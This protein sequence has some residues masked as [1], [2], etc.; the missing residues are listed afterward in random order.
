M[1]NNN[2]I[3]ISAGV[4]SSEQDFTF[5]SNQIIGL[6][7]LGI[8]GEMKKGQAF[9]PTLVQSYGEYLECFGNCDPCV[10]K[11]T[12]QPIYEASFIAKQFLR[13]SNS[14]YVTRVLGL[15][16]YNAGTGWAITLGG[17]IDLSTATPIE[18]VDFTMTKVYND[19]SCV[20]VIFDD[21]T[22]QTLYDCGQI[23]CDDLGSV[24]MTSGD[25]I[26][27][28]TRWYGDCEKFFGADLTAELLLEEEK[29][30]C[31]TGSTLTGT[32]AD[33]VSTSV[34]GCTIF[35][36]GSVTYGAT[37]TFDLGNGGCQVSLIDTSSST[38]RIIESGVIQ[39]NG[40]TI[41]HNIDGTI[42]IEDGT[43]IL[44]SGE[45]IHDGLY[46]ICKFECAELKYLGCVDGINIT[47]QTGETTATTQVYVT[48]TT[49]IVAKVPSG[50]VTQ[51]WSGS[52]NHYEALPKAEYDNRVVA[53]LRS[54]AYYDS[55][56][57]LTFEVPLGNVGIQPVE[58]TISPLGDFVLA[59]I[60]VQ[61]NE[62]SYTLSLDR[63]KRN[64]I[65]RV[66]ADEINGVCCENEAPLYIEEFYEGMLEKYIEEGCV[67]CIKPKLICCGNV[68]DYQQ[69]YQHA[70]TP[71]IVSEVQGGGVQRLFRFH[72][73]S[74]GNVANTDVK[75]SITNIRP[76]EGTFDVLVR[77]YGDSDSRPVV[78]QRFSRLTMNPQSNNYVARKIGD[79]DNCFEGEGCYVRIE[80]AAN[81]VGDVFP[82]GFEGYP[83]RDYCE[84]QIPEFRYKKCYDDFE[85]KR[86]FFLGISD[87]EGIDKD[88]F[89]YKGKMTNGDEWTGRTKGFHLDIN[90]PSEQFE[91][92]C[93]AFQNNADLEGTV[94]DHI[95]SRK[96]TV[97]FYG[98]FD[99][100]DVHRDERTNKDNFIVRGSQGSK[101]LLSGAFEPY[102]N[103]DDETVINSDF[104]AWQKAIW[105]FRN[106]QN[107]D[108]NIITTP[109]I[110]STE[111]TLLIEETIE[112]VEEDRCDSIYIFTT[113]DT[114][115]DW[116]TPLDADSLVDQIEGLYDSSYAATYAGWGKTSCNDAVTGNFRIWIP[117]T[118]E[119]VRS[120][121]YTDKVAANWYAAAGINRGRTDF[122]QLRVNWNQED[123]DTLYE[124][125]INPLT[126]FNNIGGAASGIYIWGNKTVQDGNGTESA[127]SRINVR[128]LL[129]RV[130]KLIAESSQQLLFEQNDETLRSQFLNIINPILESIRSQRGLLDFRAEVDSI[131]ASGDSNKLCG[132]IVIR[133]TRAA[134]VLCLNY[135]VSNAGAFFES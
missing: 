128:R 95:N 130:R 104:Y 129:L 14:L 58:K 88:F 4:Y 12:K 116:E 1:A 44:P 72:T 27:V 21:A 80:M 99:G 123:R 5:V 113:L 57:I 62:F 31:I 127:L 41:T 131:D 109:T 18:T 47:C 70:V 22:L 65:K 23:T 28:G 110:N 79:I 84:A 89:S 87:T 42:E 33:I 115:S 92:G 46:R 45:L 124:G 111:H 29:L 26:S 76:D 96:F 10:Y 63:T 34:T 20:S 112:M 134:E 77:R 121:A 8:V 35:S 24:D 67:H 53:M 25:T 51:V 40:G 61:G 52:T 32:S 81:C 43:I 93:A 49:D 126:K 48:G 50:I 2:G 39:F 19:G 78:L 132:R 133:P 86:K 122:E 82:S 103:D 105:T 71:Y 83:I 16:G 100:W 135:E 13:E 107:I 30:L 97:A 11:G 54:K 6:T 55:D 85:K 59:G 117:P 3:F 7:S 106:P 9:Q 17:A 38:I 120:F 90:A 15:T 73:V 74:D 114:E 64:F 108:I 94:Y 118:A 60:D 66:F 56:Q 37:L 125:R 102:I 119:V 36:G 98:G 75:V 69:E 91:V 68:W 101:G